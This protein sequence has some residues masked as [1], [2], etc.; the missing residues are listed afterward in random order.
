MKRA[1]RLLQTERITIKE[2]SDRCGFSDTSYFCKVFRK[3]FKIS[4]EVFRNRSATTFK[5]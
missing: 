5:L 1:V 2:I 4:P 3:E